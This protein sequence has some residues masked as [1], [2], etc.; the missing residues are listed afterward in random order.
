LA[1]I[2]AWVKNV[3]RRTAYRLTFGWKRNIS[4]CSF[5]LLQQDPLIQGWVQEILKS[6]MQYFPELG[7]I[8]LIDIKIALH[9]RDPNRIWFQFGVTQNHTNPEVVRKLDASISQDLRPYITRSAETP[10][11][12]FQGESSKT[13]ARNGVGQYD[14]RPS[15][16]NGVEFVVK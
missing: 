2:E 1:E 4:C 11:Q 15:I 7:W 12:F 13:D 16:S 14:A 8:P 3:V 9:D 6:K 10:V 5:E